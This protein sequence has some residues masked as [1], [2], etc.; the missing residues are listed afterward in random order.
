MKN[1]QSIL[2]TVLI[3]AFIVLLISC[4]KDIVEPTPPTVDYSTFTDARDRKI[5][6]TIKISNQEWMAEN[7]AYKTIG[8]SWDYGGSEILGAKYGRLYTWDAAQSAMPAGWH[9][10]SD[11]EWKQLEMALGMSQIEADGIEGRG[12]NEGDKLRATTGW[13]EDGNGTNEIGFTALPG[14]FRT[15]SGDIYLDNWIG[16]WW[17]ATENDN[18]SAWFRFIATSNP[19]VYRKSGYKEDAYSVRCVKD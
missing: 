15:N 9:L 2:K 4:N 11:E 13:A 12:T 16:Y 17:T 19:K 14:G 6:K 10:P 3:F 18:L 8:G 5:Y 1:K 7:L